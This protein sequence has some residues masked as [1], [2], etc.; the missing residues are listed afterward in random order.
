[1]RMRQ[2]H[3]VMTVLAVLSAANQAPTNA[4]SPAWPETN[5]APKK[6]RYVDQRFL[7]LAI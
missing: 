3:K 1:M 5:T 2:L 4:G 6:G 7:R